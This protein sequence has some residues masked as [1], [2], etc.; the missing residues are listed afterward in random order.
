[1]TLIATPIW[2]RGTRPNSLHS[3]P[4]SSALHSPVPRKSGGK[5]STAL[6]NQIAIPLEQR[7][8]ARSPVIL[9]RHVRTL[10][11]SVSPERGPRH[12]AS[13]PNGIC[14]RWCRGTQ[15]ASTSGHHPQPE[16]RGLPRPISLC[17][18]FRSANLVSTRLHLPVRSIFPIGN[19]AG[20]RHGRIPALL[21]VLLRLP[22]TTRE[23]VN[24]GPTSGQGH[25]FRLVN[26]GRSIKLPGHVY[27]SIAIS[28]G[29][30]AG[31]ILTL[32]ILAL[33]ASGA[34]RV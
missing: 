19:M 30:I 32:K 26:L 34:L 11:P 17:G 27:Q 2:E 25:P 20:K 29:E 31:R 16:D 18:F 24:P 7:P 15:R 1:M 4:I 9:S 10:P 21:A 22:Y 6:Y 23:V 3:K 13:W 28:P 5:E 8:A 33:R 14:P 12:S